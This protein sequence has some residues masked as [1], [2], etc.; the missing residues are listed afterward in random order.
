MV[1]SSNPTTTL[2]P[3]ILNS[4]P[5]AGTN[6]L[7][8]VLLGMPNVFVVPGKHIFG[9]PPS[10]HEQDW[11]L[12]NTLQE[13][14]MLLG[15][16]NYSERWA[17]MMHSLNLK[18]VFILRDPRDVVVSLTYFIMSELPHHQ[19]YELFNKKGM[20]QK[21][22]YLTLIHG[23]EDLKHGGISNYFH[24]Y[25]SWLRDPNTHTV[26]YEQLMESEATRRSAIYQTAK[27]LWSGLTPPMSLFEMTKRME[28]NID[29]SK[30][31]TFR[32][33]GIGNW[34]KEF[35][36]EVVDAF[37]EAAGDLLIELGYEKDKN[38]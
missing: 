38:W 30:S 3:F 10:D 31:W 20:T 6:L 28:K 12:L 22:R 11:K 5:K 14:E 4:V 13:N 23:V 33:G 17:N 36:Q 9:G 2:P 21:Q 32:K 25:T 15:H 1:G 27:F 34:K 26:T 8:Q 18:Q 19:F 7:R 24:L 35:D 29:P 37:K 16:V